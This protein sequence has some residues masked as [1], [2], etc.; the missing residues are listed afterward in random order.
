MQFAFVISFLAGISTVLGS[1]VLFTSYK[2]KDKLISK[3]LA[4]A[5]GVMLTVSVLDLIPNSI[6]NLNKIFYIFPAIILSFIFIVLGIIISL[7]INKYLPSYENSSDSKLYKVGIFAMLALVLHNIP[8][9]V[10]T[11]LTTTENTTLGISLAIAIALH[12]I[13]EGISISVP[14]YFSTKNKLKAI[15]YTFISGISEFFGAVLAYLFLTGI[16]ASMF[17]DLLYSVIAGIMISLAVEELIPNAVRYSKK[18]YVAV[19]V[20]IGILFMSFVHFVL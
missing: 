16:D 10:V 7:M 20:V 12:N 15:W 17:V 5:S 9:G 13:P 3:S 11:Y 18:T 6:I 19:Y 1:L 4:F 14:I 8:E 2:K